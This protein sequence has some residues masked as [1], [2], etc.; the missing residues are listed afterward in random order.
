MSVIDQLT[1]VLLWIQFR[2]G[3]VLLLLVLSTD[4]QGVW[5]PRWSLDDRNEIFTHLDG[6]FN[7][8]FLQ[9]FALGQAYYPSQYAPTKSPSDV[10][11][12]EF[13]NEAHRRDIKVSAWINIFYSWG[14]GPRTTEQMHPVN[15]YPHWYVYDVDGRSILDYSIDELR[16]L[17]TEGYYLAPAHV[18]VRSYLLNIINE[19]TDLYDFD[20]IHLDYARYPRRS[21]VYDAYVRSKFMR[22]FHV[23]P[24][25]LVTCPDMSQRYGVWGVDDLKHQWYEFVADDLTAFIKD[26]QASIKTERRVL[27]SVAVKPQ[28]QEARSQYFQDW[29]T[30]LNEGY[31][32]F[33]CLMSYGKNLDGMVNQALHAVEEP[34]RV[35]VGLGLYLLTPHQIQRQ[36]NLVRS[37][38]FSG[39]VFFSYDQLKENK[40]YLHTLK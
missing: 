28:Y 34:Q 16:R 14:F 8:I 7:H 1:I 21:F 4:F 36:V 10:W 6:K 32:D 35:M 13:L 37:K 30:W 40:A 27:L 19:I 11:L 18:H 25:E 15:M 9:I 5:I 20:G 26:V 33:V 17:S 29:V 24:F 3:A 31:V 12:K 39:V 23:D 38:P 22:Q 2:V